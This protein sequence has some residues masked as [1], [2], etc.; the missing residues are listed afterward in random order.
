MLLDDDTWFDWKGMQRLLR[1]ADWRDPVL[2]SYILADAQVIGYDYPCG[3]AGMV[4][5]RAALNRIVRPLGQEEICPFV[6]FNDLSLALCLST[7]GVP[8]VHVSQMHCMPTLDMPARN[9]DNLNDV[10]EQVFHSN[11]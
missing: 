7:F 9:Y 11:F 1:G 8:M 2:F 10:L 4:V 5:S 3:G 6:Q